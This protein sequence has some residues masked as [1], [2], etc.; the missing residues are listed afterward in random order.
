MSVVVYP[1]NNI[2]FSAEDVALYNATRTSG[3]YSDGDFALSLSGSNNTISVDVGMGWMRLSRFVGV[4]VALKSKT[5]VDMGLPDSIYPRIDAVVLQFDANKNGASVIAKKGSASSNPQPPALTQTEAVY[6][7]H[8][9][10][11]LR[12]PGAVSITAADVTDM[13]L[14]PVYCGIMA[15]A[16]SAV[17]TSAISAQVSALIQKFR[18]EIASVSSGTYYASKEYVQDYTRTRKTSAVLYA[19]GWSGTGPYTQNVTISD[20]TTDKNARAY[21][22]VPDGA[23][24]EAELADESAK[25]SSCRRNGSTLIF[26]C[27]EDKPA[28]NIPVIVEVYV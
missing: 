16:V 21:V 28:L 13:R 15:D 7:L 17:D 11:V 19:T 5:A 24:S 9:A 26:R 10:H 2:D 6:E 12:N 14:N 20:L 4:A 8:L 27:L 25:V 23:Q 3:V 22:D 18:D 1:L